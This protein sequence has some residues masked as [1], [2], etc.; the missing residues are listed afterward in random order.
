MLSSH[1]FITVVRDDIYP[2]AQRIEQ[3]CLNLFNRHTIPGRGPTGVS[4]SNEL[5]FTIAYLESA[6]TFLRVLG[7][8]FKLLEA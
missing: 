5:D 1:E 6:T 4:G 8:E 3:D 7:R 2:R